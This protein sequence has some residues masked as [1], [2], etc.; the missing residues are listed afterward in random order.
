[1]G[2]SL[3]A[4]LFL[5]LKGAPLSW[6]LTWVERA[7]GAPGVQSGR[8]AELR[9]GRLRRECLHCPIR[10]KTIRWLREPIYGVGEESG[11]LAVDE[12]RAVPSIDRLLARV[13]AWKPSGYRLRQLPAPELHQ[14]VSWTRPCHR[15]CP[16][17]RIEAT[18]NIQALR[19]L[20]T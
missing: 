2:A 16:K 8:L 5:T 10:K 13:W 9:H 6:G 3:C 17:W 18:S 4:G 14:V 19:S 15:T 7:L 20:P 11:G 1:M 12:G